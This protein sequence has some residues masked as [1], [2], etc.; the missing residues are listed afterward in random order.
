MNSCD[1]KCL[2]KLNLTWEQSNVMFLV[3][4]SDGASL[5]ALRPNTH[6]VF[7]TES[8]YFQSTPQVPL[9][10]TSATQVNFVFSIL[11]L[12]LKSTLSHS[13]SSTSSPRNPTCVWCTFA[14]PGPSLC[15]GHPF[16]HASLLTLPNHVC[17]VTNPSLPNGPSGNKSGVTHHWLWWINR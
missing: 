4:P 5:Y 3:L 9:L 16:L 17:P 15:R 13:A 14:A 11:S 8:W 12:S 10:K 2:T 6:G 1:G 7:S